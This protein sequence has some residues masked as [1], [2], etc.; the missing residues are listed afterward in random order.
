MLGLL[1]LAGLVAVITA[2]VR[3][4]TRTRLSAPYLPALPRKTRRVRLAKQR[5]KRDRSTT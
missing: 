4:N 2:V 1:R 3:E 5:E